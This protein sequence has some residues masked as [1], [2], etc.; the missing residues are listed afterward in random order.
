MMESSV[1]LVPSQRKNGLSHKLED[2]NRKK[3]KSILSNTW[4]DLQSTP[5]DGWGNGY[6]KHSRHLSFS[7]KHIF[8]EVTHLHRLPAGFSYTLKVDDFRRVVVE[9][10]TPELAGGNRKLGLTLQVTECCEDIVV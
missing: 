3:K 9:L 6:Q 5:T 7:K 4:T 8:Q 2:E 10:A 1:P